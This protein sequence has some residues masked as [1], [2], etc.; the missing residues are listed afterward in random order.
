[1]ASGEGIPYVFPSWWNREV[2]LSCNAQSYLEN[3]CIQKA[4]P[5]SVF[6]A[7]PSNDTGVETSDQTN[8]S[9]EHVHFQTIT[10]PSC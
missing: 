4:L 5:V 7:F 9:V 2:G 3:H 1:M 6:I 8:E 10:K